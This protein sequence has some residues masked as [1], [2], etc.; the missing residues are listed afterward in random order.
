M[1]NTHDMAIPELSA[2]AAP[3]PS[4]RASVRVADAFDAFVDLLRRPIGRPC[5]VPSRAL[6]S[7]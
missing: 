2:H 5:L 1:R 4:L 7:R 3:P 6:G